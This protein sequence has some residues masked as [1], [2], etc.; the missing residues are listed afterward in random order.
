MASSKKFFFYDL[1]I[2]VSAI[3]PFI[4]KGKELNYHTIEVSSQQFF[5]SI[6]YSIYFM[7]LF[8]F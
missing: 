8:L 4:A 6:Q 3:T 1:Q 5:F 7:T 2:V